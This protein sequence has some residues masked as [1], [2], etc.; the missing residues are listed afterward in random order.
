MVANDQEIQILK[1]FVDYGGF[2][3]DPKIVLESLCTLSFDSLPITINLSNFESIIFNFFEV[4]NF[5]VVGMKNCNFDASYING[6][7]GEKRLG[8]NRSQ[9]KEAT[10][11][12]ENM[13][14]F[15]KFYINSG[16]DL[17][18]KT[19]GYLQLTGDVQSYCISQNHEFLSVFT[20]DN[21]LATF[22]IAELVFREQQANRGEEMN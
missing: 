7:D 6:S 3:D 11:A 14:L 2:N 20:S 13:I 12:L 4:S 8:S 15:E 17:T 19:L 16:S 21:A 1:S 18:S 10:R 22:K 9:E 5:F